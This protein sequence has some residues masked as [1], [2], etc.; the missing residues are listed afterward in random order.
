VV[1]G[2]NGFAIASMILGILWIYWVGSI[3]ALVFGYIALRQIK[4]RAEGGRGMAIAGV[5][6]GWIGVAMIPVIVIAV[7]AV[8]SSVKGDFKDTCQQFSQDGT[9][10][11]GNC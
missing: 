3:L 4:Q 2:T 11:T 10:T 8:G 6:L 1:A 5:V 9:S 7:F